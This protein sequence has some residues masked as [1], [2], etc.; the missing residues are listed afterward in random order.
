MLH[1]KIDLQVE[2]NSKIFSVENLEAPA[3]VVYYLERQV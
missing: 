2:F 1:D 3:S